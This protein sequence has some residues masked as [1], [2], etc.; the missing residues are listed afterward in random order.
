MELRKRR[1]TFG[2]AA[3]IAL[4]A[5]AGGGLLARRIVA[6]E[7]PAPA[8]PAQPGTPSQQD[9][10]GGALIAALEHSPGCLGVDAGQMKSGKLSIFAWFKD[11]QAVLDWYYGAAHQQ[12]MG[13]MLVGIEMAHHAAAKAAPAGAASKS[14]PPPVKHTP[15]EFVPDGTGPILCIA[16][17]TPSEKP[18]V[19]GFPLAVGQISIELYQPL[20]GGVS[21]G[22][23][24]APATMKIEHHQRIGAS[25][26]TAP[27]APAAPRKV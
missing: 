6:Q 14:E 16:S 20:P 9:D 15:L 21:I 2:L 11:K 25:P 12:A 19:P 13:A 10:L 1:F 7:R 17:I 24:F 3:A 5:L 18:L 22:G 8:A 23:T 27:A 26:S 4:A